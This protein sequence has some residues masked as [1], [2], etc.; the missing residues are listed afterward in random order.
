MCMHWLLIATIFREANVN[1]NQK[2][3]ITIKLHVGDAFR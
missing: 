1:N 2:L 3:Y